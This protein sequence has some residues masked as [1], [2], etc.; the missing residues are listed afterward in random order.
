MSESETIVLESAQSVTALAWGAGSDRLLL[1][2]SGGWFLQ[3]DLSGQVTKKR[4][5]HEGPILQVQFSPD[6]CFV[7]SVGGDHTLQVGDEPTLGQL[8]HFQTVFG[9]QTLDVSWSP[10]GSRLVV[11]AGACHILEM[12]SLREQLL[13]DGHQRFWRDGLTSRVAWSPDG[14]QIV[15]GGDRGDLGTLRLWTPQKGETLA[16]ARIHPE[17]VTALAW[18]PQGTLIAS[19]GV[20]SFFT[21]RVWGPMTD[22]LLVPVPEWDSVFSL[23]WEEQTSCLLY[24][25]QMAP[26]LVRS[27]YDANLYHYEKH[28]SEKDPEEERRYL[29]LWSPDG[30]WIASCRGRSV[31]IWSPPGAEE[32]SMTWRKPYDFLRSAP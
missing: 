29:A 5:V 17:G 3:Y 6:M 32:R 22:Q 8:I 16:Q 11:A 31:H 30:K 10:D 21:L 20:N 18:N 15:S 9:E 25:G 27:L 26:T 28:L 12:G 13:Y 23:S 24:A 14:R 1:G 4:K 7:A 19:G 2:T